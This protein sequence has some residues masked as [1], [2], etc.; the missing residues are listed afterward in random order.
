MVDEKA[1]AYAKEHAGEGGDVLKIYE[2]Y[3]DGHGDMQESKGW[4]F[5]VERLLC[6]ETAACF[7]W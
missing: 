4:P 3:K 7:S 1:A 6:Y 5:L 2:A